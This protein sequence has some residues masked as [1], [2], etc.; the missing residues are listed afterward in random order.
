MNKPKHHIFLCASYRVSGTPQGTCSKKGAIQFLPYLESALDERGLG[1]VVV[2][3]T[4]C[5][6]MCEKGPVMVIYPENIWYAN[7]ESEDAIDEILDSLEKGEPCA[8]YLI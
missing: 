3:S 2:S 6:K 5:L 7:V 1:D 4:G 8:K